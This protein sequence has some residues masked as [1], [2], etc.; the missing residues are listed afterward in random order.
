MI[1]LAGIRALAGGLP[2]WAWFLIGGALLLL[3][4][5]LA[6]DA[7][8]DRRYDAGKKDADAAWIEAGNKLVA[9]A[10]N[11]ASKADRAAAARA[12]DFTAKQEEEKERIEHAKETGASPFDVLFGSGNA[13]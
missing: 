11:S 10:Q 9:K 4:F 12:E 6:L 2:R 8:G 1:G 13:S 7:Y 5:Y 3:A